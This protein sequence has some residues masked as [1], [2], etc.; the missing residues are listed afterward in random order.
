MDMKLPEI[1]DHPN[2]FPN[3][4]LN[5][6][7]LN[8]K[9]GSH[10]SHAIATT[11]VR[12]VEAA[13]SDYRLARNLTLEFWD[14]STGFKFGALNAATS[15]FESCITN[16]HRAVRC[17]IGLHSRTDIPD[18]FRCLISPKPTFTKGAIERQI[19][20]VRATIQH[21]EVKVERGEVPENTPFFV[22]ADGPEVPVEGDPGQTIKTID[23][24]VIG[25]VEILLADLCA[26][27]SEMGRSADAIA[28]FRRAS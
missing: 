13:L 28:S 1:V 24:L 4:W 5:V 27:L 15:H 6:F 3:H 14:V 18:D 19:R 12:C 7:F 20:T 16:M 25:S 11:Y 10:Q 17:M 22:K 21:M 2:G 23:R 9:P 8:N 26:W